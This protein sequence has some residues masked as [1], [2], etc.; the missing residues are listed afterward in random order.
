MPE[1]DDKPDAKII[2]KQL[3]YAV[4]GCAQR[5]HSRIGNGFPEHVYQKAMSIELEKAGIVHRVEAPATVTYD[6]VVC[7][8]FR[9]DI[10]VDN[11]IVLELKAVESLV[12]RHKAQTLSYLR[13]CD[14]RLGILMNFGETRLV[15][16]RIVN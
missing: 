8:E 12:D 1:G 3:S 6:G 11:K 7:G 2:H 14:V 16:K 13:A 9:I 15:T 4:V 5:V 10:L